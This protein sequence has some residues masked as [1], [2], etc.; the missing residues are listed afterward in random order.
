MTATQKHIE[1]VS[2][3][4]QVGVSL[5]HLGSGEYGLRKNDALRVLDDLCH[6]DTFPL[7]IELWKKKADSYWLEAELGWYSPH[8]KD[9]KECCQSAKRYINGG[10]VGDLDLLTIQFSGNPASPE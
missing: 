7:G 3:I 1:I 10:E 9:L 5:R 2:F 6:N 8:G 4:K